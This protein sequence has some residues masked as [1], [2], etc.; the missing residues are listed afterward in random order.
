MQFEPKPWLEVY[1]NY[2][3]RAVVH[4]HFLFGLFARSGFALSRLISGNSDAVL[5]I[6]VEN[7]F[8]AAIA[9]ALFFLVLMRVTESWRMALPLA[10]GLC[11]APAY[12]MAATNIA[13]VGLALPFFV[14]ALYLLNRDPSI[15]RVVLLGVIAALAADTYLL[16]GALVP[17]IAIALVDPASKTPFRK[18]TLSLLFLT[19]F[20]VCFLGIWLGVLYI[21]GMHRLGALVTA[22]L[23]F[24][25]EGTYGGFKLSSLIATPIGLVDA[26]FGALPANFVGLRL[27]LRQSTGLAVFVLGVGLSLVVV[28]VATCRRLWR[29]GETWKPVVVAAVVAFLLIEAACIEWDPYYRKL[30]L[31]AAILLL[32][33]LA[34]AFSHTRFRFRAPVSVL[35]LAGIIVSGGHQLIR[36]RKP[37]P[38]IT[39][40][41]KLHEIVR[42][43]PLI[44]GWSSDI[45]HLWLYSN[46]DNIIS[47]PD[48]AFARHLNSGVVQSDLTRLVQQSI[49]GGQS[50]FF[51][52]LFSP[53][54]KDLAH[55]YE[56]RFHLD[57]LSGF[58]EDLKERSR[59]VAKFQ[60][61]GAADCFLYELRPD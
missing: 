47:I 60:Q 24:P 51:Y 59:P 22:V 6:R 32:L 26:L 23:H 20:G 34:A 42:Q 29:S 55:V 50:V 17:G 38:A 49:S 56:T 16:A 13:E 44:T 2:Y 14:G 57:G 48:F 54:D 10:F 18:A 7:A 27:F 8:A 30:Q 33:L 15:K 41:Q 52:G 36:N 40:A 53:S 31:F 12:I 43:R 37:S 19:V 9:A 28:I 4:N 61:A 35:F 39:N 5:A 21:S 3:E 11:F 45:A 1:R 25:Q 58:L 46:G